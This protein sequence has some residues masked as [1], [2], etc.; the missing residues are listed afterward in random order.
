M[1]RYLVS[2]PCVWSIEVEEEGINT[3]E[4]AANWAEADYPATIDGLAYVI[5]L[6][7]NEVFED[8]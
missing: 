8:V 7:T 5:D 3:P 6:D 4:E 2:F 1:K